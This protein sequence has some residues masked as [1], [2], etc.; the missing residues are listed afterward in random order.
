MGEQ[1]YLKQH[2]AYNDYIVVTTK[3]KF[4]KV[5]AKLNAHT[6]H[7][8]ELKDVEI[9]EYIEPVIN[10]TKNKVEVTLCVFTEW[11]GLIKRKYV[12][13]RKPPHLFKNRRGFTESK[14]IVPYDCKIM[15]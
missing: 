13:D 2:G 8:E 10:K 15:F 14:V 4:Y 6:E 12:F 3:D 5:V 11:G 7:S 1:F 9:F